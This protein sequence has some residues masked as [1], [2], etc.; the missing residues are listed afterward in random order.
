MNLSLSWITNNFWLKLAS[1]LLAVGFWFYVVGEESIEITKTVPLEI[2]TDSEKV[3]LVKSSTSYLEVTLESPRHLL[4]VLSSRDAKAVHIIRD[5]E[6]AGDYSFN[7]SSKDLILPAAEARVTKIFPS[8]V[9][10]SLDEV[11]VKKLPIEVDLIGEPAYGYRA[12][13]EAIE[14]DPNAVLVEGP[15]AILEK[16]D[17]IQTEPVQL[18][19]RIRTFRRRVKVREFPEVKPLG[20]AITEIQVPVIAE[21]S[22]KEFLDVPVK[23][24]GSPIARHYVRLEMDRISF[25]LKGPRAV[26]DT[27]D[28][29][30]ILAFVS[31]EDLKEGLHELPL[32]LILPT[33]LSIKGEPPLVPVEVSK[34]KV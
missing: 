5:A 17:S 29:D 19:G 7:V 14:L 10:V 24:L 27:V 8:Y 6:K 1:L 4:S 20:E 21:F 34:V 31:V 15:K 32:K 23:P 2:K 22:E 18:V 16:M 11:I 12:D 28:T 25:T 30:Q 33:D 13:T 26:L 9:T 3:S